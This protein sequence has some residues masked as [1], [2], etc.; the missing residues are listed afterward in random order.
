MTDYAVSN[1]QI[2]QR[3]SN[4]HRLINQPALNEATASMK[5]LP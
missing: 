1:S 2:D 4:T 5:R 3:M